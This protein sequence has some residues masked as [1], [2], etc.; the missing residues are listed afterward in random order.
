MTDGGPNGSR[1]NPSECGD[2]FLWCSVQ[3]GFES[4]LQNACRRQTQGKSEDSSRATT[5]LNM[6]VDICLSR[7]YIST[8]IWAPKNSTLPSNT[9]SSQASH[10]NWHLYLHMSQQG[11]VNTLFNL[12][13]NTREQFVQFGCSKLIR[14]HRRRMHTSQI[15]LKILAWD[16]STLLYVEDLESPAMDKSTSLMFKIIVSGRVRQ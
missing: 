6:A 16:K 5:K 15:H 10:I 14:W 13:F 4:P 2:Q 12:V 1:S 8:Y 9:G 7:F 3:A 11:T